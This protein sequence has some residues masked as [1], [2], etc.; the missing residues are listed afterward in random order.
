MIHDHFGQSR[1]RCAAQ[2]RATWTL[3]WIL[4]LTAAAFFSGCSSSSSAHGGADA[5][6]TPDRNS[7]A[8]AGQVV[9]TFT[10]SLIAPTADDSS[11]HTSIVG[12]V[13]DGPTPAQ[14]V[15]EPGVAADG[16]QLSTPRVPFCSTSCGGSAVCVED[17]TCQDYPTAH[18]V[19]TV[20]VTGIKTSTGTTSFSMD[21]V[22]KTYQPSG[23]IKLPFP[24]FAEGDAIRLAAVGGDYKAFT[25]SARGVAP[26]VLSSTDIQLA[27]AQP[28]QLTWTAAGDPDVSKIHVKLDISH[29]GGSKGMIECDVDDDGALDISADLMTAL[30]NLGAAGYPTIIVTR[31]ADGSARIAPGIVDLTVTS[32][33]EAAVKVPGLASCNANTDCPTGETCQSD[34]SCK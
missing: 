25:L 14:L 10:V 3:S 27:T 16:C 7:D 31:H 24:A 6:A 30:L 23:D 17:D 15:W 1:S 34:L 28:L 4:P 22:A 20:A 33:V 2:L 8:G 12:K 21:P 26:L 19:G 18:T 11:G 13:S 32:Q 5:A 29:H 9:G